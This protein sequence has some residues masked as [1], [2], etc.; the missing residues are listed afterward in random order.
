MRQ[1]R[2]Q[3]M[4]S[5]GIMF[6][7]N[8]ITSPKLKVLERGCLWIYCSSLVITY[9]CRTSRIDRLRGKPITKESWAI[10]N[11]YRLDAQFLQLQ[12]CRGYSCIQWHALKYKC[13]IASWKRRVIQ[14]LFQLFPAVYPIFASSTEIESA[15]K[16]LTPLRRAYRAGHSVSLPVTVTPGT[17]YR[18]SFHF[19]FRCADP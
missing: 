6:Y 10:S 13:N 4:S 2:W 8:Y 1:W 5:S 17:S 7:E 11:Y 12:D 15:Y 9:R 3:W 16:S 14:H 18:F 19:V